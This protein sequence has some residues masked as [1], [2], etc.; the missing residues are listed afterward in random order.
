[1]VEI[2]YKK[3]L[4]RAVCLDKLQSA[5]RGGGRTSSPWISSERM[6]LSETFIS[7]K[8]SPKNTPPTK[9][10]SMFHRRFGKA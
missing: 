5:A 10:G 2:R 8:L 9:K 6:I 7:S 4:D 1:M 3:P